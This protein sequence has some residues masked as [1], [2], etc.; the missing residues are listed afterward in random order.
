[1]KLKTT[2][3]IL[4]TILLIPEIT[5]SAQ[6]MRPSPM[7]QQN[8]AHPDSYSQH[9]PT[10]YDNRVRTVSDYS[11]IHIEAPEKKTYKVNDI[12]TIIV[13]E[14]AQVTMQSIFSRQKTSQLKAELKDFIRIG[15]GGNLE[16][17]ASNSPTIDAN[18]QGRINATGQV[19]ETEGVTYRIAATVVDVLP[20]G[21]LVLEA[22]KT[23]RTNDDQAIYMLTGIIRYNDI[24]ANNSVMSENI[25]NLDVA[26]LQSGKTFDSTKRYWGVKIYDYIWPF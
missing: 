24:L 14:K 10:I 26:K 25:A 4:F 1:M 19:D 9:A 15:A 3:F 8:G 21:N 2:T 18:L 7:A 16:N 23:I 17:A 11:W 6:V 22:R 5:A 13:N 20:N 12:I